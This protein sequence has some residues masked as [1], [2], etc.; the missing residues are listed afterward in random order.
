MLH[1]SRR[2]FL[3]VAS[4]LRQFWYMGAHQ[5]LKKIAVVGNAKV[6]QFMG[7]DEILE[8]WRVVGQST[9][10]VNAGRRCHVKCGRGAKAELVAAHYVHIL[11]ERNETIKL[12]LSK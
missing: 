5:S 3:V 10:A 1:E 7:D 11:I 4:N 12:L 6:E 2:A 9:L 8:T